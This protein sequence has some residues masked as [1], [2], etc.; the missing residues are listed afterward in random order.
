MKKKTIWTPTDKR[1]V[2]FLDILG[3]KDMVMRSSHIDIYAK[4]DKLSKAKKAIEEATKNYDLDDKVGNGEIYTVSFSDSIV[5]FSKTDDLDNFKFFLVAVRWIFAKAIENEIPLKGG[6][7]HGEISLNKSEQIYFGQAIIDA[8]QLE[9]DVN[10]FGITAHFSI[11]KYIA[12][13][14]DKLDMNY[15]NS[16]VFD[17]MTPLKSGQIEH[18][19]I[20]WFVKL[21]KVMNTEEENI[22]TKEIKK[23]ITDYRMTCSGSPRKYVDNTLQVLNIRRK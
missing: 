21:D 19:N 9:E 2:A 11:D 8:Y 1:F 23:I 14:K 5:V 22:K 12:D 4:L 20:D 15:I 7:A 3:F 16:I 17:C 6:I 18:K 10:Y 13:N